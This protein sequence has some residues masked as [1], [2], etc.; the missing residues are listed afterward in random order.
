MSTHD[1]N[2]KLNLNSMTKDIDLHAFRIDSNILGNLS[3][4]INIYVLTPDTLL[5]YFFEPIFL[6][7]PEK[8]ISRTI[9]ID[10]LELIPFQIKKCTCTLICLI[11]EIG[12]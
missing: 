11:H 9:G 1:F 2:L 10:M 4:L 7:Q 6:H 12:K 8:I 3:D 5:K